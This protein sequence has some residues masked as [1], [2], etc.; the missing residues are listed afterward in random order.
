VN[1]LLLLGLGEATSELIS[2]CSILGFLSRKP[3]LFSRGEANSPQPFFV[4]CIILVRLDDNVE[5]RLPLIKLSLESLSSFSRLKV[6]K[7]MLRLAPSLTVLGLKI[8]SGIPRT[9]S[10]SSI[11]SAKSLHGMPGRDLNPELPYSSRM[12]Y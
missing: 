2:F 6:L 5:K 8:A 4:G 1:E 9:S 7:E 11:R 3:T 10:S 12:H